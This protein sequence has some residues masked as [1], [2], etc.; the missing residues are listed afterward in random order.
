MHFH[1]ISRNPGPRHARLPIWWLSDEIEPTFSASPA[2][3]ME[4][5]HFVA[6]FEAGL[7]TNSIVFC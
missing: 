4:E 6:F 1:I 3:V 7:V 5:E 2:E